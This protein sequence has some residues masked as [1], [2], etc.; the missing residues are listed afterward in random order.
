MNP[1]FLGA[2]ALLALAL[3]WQWLSWE[4]PRPTPDPSMTEYSQRL[5]NPL[6][7]IL[8]QQQPPLPRED[9]AEVTERPLFMADRRRV[10]AEITTTTTDP[11]V[12]SAMLDQIRLEAILIS[13]DETLAWIREPGSSR[14]RPLRLNDRLHGWSVSAI[15]ATC[16]WLERSGLRR[17]LWLRPLGDDNSPA[18]P[19]PPPT[20]SG[21][22]PDRT[23]PSPTVG[24]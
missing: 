11:T 8:S 9:Y 2:M 13:K 21:A 7:D 16:I 17:R 1:L 18:S 10:S 6:A 3:A 23:T 24:P 22:S 5:G 14:A 20:P 4:D 15:E 12:D 19:A